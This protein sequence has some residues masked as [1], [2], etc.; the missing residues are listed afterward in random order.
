MNDILKTNK[1]HSLNIDP[2]S[3]VSHELKTPLSILKLNVEML[4]K[5]IPPEQEKF[6]DIINT[7]VDWMIQFISDT[8]DMKKAQNKTNL[9]LKWHKWNQWIQKIQNRLENT[10]NLYKGNLKLHF[11]DKEIE[12]YMDPLYIRQVLLNLILNAIE[13]SPENSTVEISWEQVKGQKLKIQVMDQGPGITPDSS[14]KIFEPFHKEREKKN[15]LIKGSG[16]GLT[17][18]KQVIQAHNNNVWVSNRPKNNGAVF[19]FTLKVR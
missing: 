13:H 1:K 9:N 7:E 14:D 17:I 6:I 16:L 12:V 5:Q 19:A 8:L 10:G 18:V 4:K 3:F 2:L 11:T 15:H